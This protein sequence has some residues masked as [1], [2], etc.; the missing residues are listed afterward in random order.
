[1]KKYGYLFIALG[2]I[3]LLTGCRN[4][5]FAEKEF[6]KASK[7]L[8][9]VEESI[10]VNHSAPSAVH[11]AAIQAFER[12]VEKFPASGKALESQ[13]IIAQLQ[14]EQA[15]YSA[16]RAVLDR[17]VTN[18]TGLTGAAGA[19]AADARFRIAKLYEAEGNWPMAEKVF[20]EMAEYHPVYKHGLYSPSYV[21]LHYKKVKD[22]VG[23]E[24]A[25]I[26]AKEHYESILQSLGP[27]QASGSARHYL[28]VIYLIKGDWRKARDGWL[29]M[30]EDL[31]GNAGVPYAIVSAADVVAENDS[32]EAGIGLYRRYLYQ[33]P[34]HALRG[35]VLAQIGLLEGRRK[36]FD[37][38][39]MW[40]ERAMS[41]YAGKGKVA[42]GELKL[43]IGQSYQKEGNWD[44]AD[45]YYE[46]VEKNYPITL[47]ALEIPLIRY[48][49][50]R[51][52]GDAERMRAL[53]DLAIRYYK[54]VIV[55][56]PGTTFEKQARRFLQ[57]VF[58]KQGNWIE[59]LK[60]VD[61]EISRERSFLKQG[62]WLLFKAVI[63]E[64]RLRNKAGALAIYQDFLG[65]FPSHPLV[66]M[67]KYHTQILAQ[68]YSS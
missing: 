41:F 48:E 4:E 47:A 63:T 61:E 37:R 5:Y 1:M 2:I 16:A 67:A 36:H 27:I 55:D 30:S 59:L 57:T 43:F 25:F 26:R 58:I 44:K 39:R 11:Q 42:V 15:N 51:S 66:K 64:R 38:A 52:A 12:V 62:Q 29:E 32:I 50:F 14:I 40:F 24:K 19:R 13:F 49:H 23:F 10:S 31:A 56:Y 65:R 53:L 8:R 20:W 18:A 54:Q 28:A 21:L 46:D 22:A 9:A 33:Y 17:I 68:N 6:Y 60:L 45:T 35:K 34:N 7:K 3:S